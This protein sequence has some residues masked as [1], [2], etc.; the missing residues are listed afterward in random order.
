MVHSPSREQLRQ[1]EQQPRYVVA[2]VCECL[3][4]R[5]VGA[6]LDRLAVADEQALGLRIARAPCA[7]ES[8]AASDARRRGDRARTPARFRPPRQPPA[9]AAAP[10]TVRPRASPCARSPRSARTASRVP[11]VG[12]RDQ[13]HAE[14][15]RDRL[16]VAVVSVEQLQHARGCAELRDRRQRVR[17]LVRGRSARRAD[18]RRARARRAPSRS[19]QPR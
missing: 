15:L 19:A 9:L 5:D 12:S 7:A 3:A 8:G 13:R 18:R 6:G 11:S 4:E 1:A 10:T 2:R 17:V 14:S 16:A